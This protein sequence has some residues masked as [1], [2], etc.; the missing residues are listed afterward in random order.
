MAHGSNDGS[1]L[2][3]INEVL[4]EPQT[5]IYILSTADFTLLWWSSCDSDP[6]TYSTKDIYYLG[7]YEKCLLIPTLYLVGSRHIVNLYQFDRRKIVAYY[8]L[9]L[10]LSY[11]KV[12]HFFH[13]FTFPLLQ[14]V[15]IHSPFFF[16]V[17]GNFLT[18]L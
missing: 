14:T 17:I 11:F 3:F 15:H 1:L 9:C 18:S 16:W 4:L 2:G 8:S 6:T 7:I 12:E 5:L 13:I 10:H